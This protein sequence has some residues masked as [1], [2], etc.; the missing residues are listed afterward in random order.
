MQ[1]KTFKAPDLAMALSRARAEFGPDALVLATNELRGRLGLTSVEITVARARS[2]ASR[3]SH[4]QGQGRGAGEPAE[5]GSSLRAAVGALVDSGLSAELAA[6]FARSASR[7]LSR[8][9]D[10]TSLIAA[11]EQGMKELVS[12]VARPLRPR[13]LFIV[14]PPGAGKTTTTAKLAARWRQRGDQPVVFANADDRKPGA[15]QQASAYSRQ[16]GL[17][18][19]RV[20]EPADLLRAMRQAGRRGSVLVDTAGIGAS[21]SERLRAL[22]RLRGAIGG[23]EVALLVPA[24]VHR[25]EARR[26]VERFRPLGPTCLG[27]SRVD[28]GC[29]LGELVTAIVPTGM[30]LAFITSG[31]DVRSRLEEASPRGLTALLLRS[32]FSPATAEEARHGL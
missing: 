30:P 8:E 6:R 15:E 26:I 28:D 1:I 18:L 10:A 29:R 32:G 13:V 25:E 24:G 21:D 27:L 31:H 22:G 7:G 20:A 9:G 3:S 14:G 4:T 17:T 11:A 16:L 19:C 2:E 5:P 12:F 23:A